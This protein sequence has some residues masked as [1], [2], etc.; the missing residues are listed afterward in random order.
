MVNNLVLEQNMQRNDFVYNKNWEYNFMKMSKMPASLRFQYMKSFE[1][2]Y[3][4]FDLE[5]VLQAH[6][7]FAFAHNQNLCSWTIT[8]F[9]NEK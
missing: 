2:R 3:F 7:S 6:L 5:C 8:N 4:C 9:L 1:K